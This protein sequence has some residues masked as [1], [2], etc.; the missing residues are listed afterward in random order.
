MWNKSDGDVS[1]VSETV[2]DF[3]K[4]MRYT[5]EDK[6]PK[7]KKRLDVAPGKSVDEGIE[8]L[9]EN[10]EEDEKSKKTK[11]TDSDDSAEDEDY[12]PVKSNYTYYLY[13]NYAYDKETASSD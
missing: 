11:K 13:Y 2:I 3:L 1:I 5:S 7:K 10:K 6:P 8:N 4:Y 9:E 12:N